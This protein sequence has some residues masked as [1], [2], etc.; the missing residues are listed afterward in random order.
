MS[1]EIWT[2]FTVEVSHTLQDPIGIPVMHGH[3][4]WV[5]CYFTT[6]EDDPVPLPML[7]GYCK[8]LRNKID[9]KHMND[10]LPVPTMEALAVWVSENLQYKPCRVVIERKSI[11][12]GL[13]YIVT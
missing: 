3:S 13:E 6:S 10:F 11:G 7:E 4:Y 1:M 8:M 9:H 2:E 5:R 12:T